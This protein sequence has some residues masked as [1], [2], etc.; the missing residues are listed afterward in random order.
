MDQNNDEPRSDEQYL[1]LDEGHRVS[2][3]FGRDAVYYWYQED[4]RVNRLPFDQ[5]APSPPSTY[6]PY[7]A[8]P[9]QMYNWTCSACALDWLK[10]AT[11]LGPSDDIYASREQ[12]VYE[13]GYPQNINPIYGLMD[14]SGKQLQRVLNDSYGTPT[15]QD[16]LNFESTYDLATYTAGL[17]GGANWY[18]WVGLRGTQGSNLWIANSAPG[19]MGIWDVL[20]ADDF[21]KLGGFSVIWLV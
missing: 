19:Y 2:Q 16:Y 9:G 8:M 18:H 11:R 12:T 7:T 3:T 20:S 13:I 6:D 17:L 1:I 15:A 14:G 21:A 4:N 10:R 5:T